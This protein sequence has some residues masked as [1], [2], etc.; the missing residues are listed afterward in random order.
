MSGLDDNDK[1]LSEENILAQW[2]AA[3]GGFG[4][5]EVWDEAAAGY[6]GRP[7]PTFVDDPFL[8]M[9]A[10]LGALGPHDGL[11]E[12]GASGK[13]ADALSSVES[14]PGTVTRSPA[15]SLT[16]LDIGCGAGLYS[17]AL[18]PFVG[19]VVGCDL[20]PMMID[21][22]RARAAEAGCKN[23]EFVCGDFADLVFEEPFDLVFAHFTPAL[24]SGAA[25][26]KMM[27]LAREWCFVAMPTRRTDPVLLEA[28]R[29][30]GVPLEADRRDVNFLNAFALA[31]LAGKTPTVEHY[32][33]VWLDQ[34]TLPDAQRVY[35]DHLVA[36]DLSEEQKALIRD[37]LAQIAQDGVV[38]ERIET[39]VVMMGWRM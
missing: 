13:L 7:T 39:T 11:S 23:A 14:M 12:G 29:L 37:Y 38:Y 30:V 8:Q 19:R 33:D 26:Q 28:R 17:I 27:A 3:P 24:G 2:T 16:V 34:R 1:I 4:Q 9:I 6:A 15:R 22:A 21:A 35:A 10:R 18:A 25:F 5:V 32:D 36:T 31:W 20:S